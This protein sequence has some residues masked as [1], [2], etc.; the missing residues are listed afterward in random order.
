MYGPNTNIVVNG[1][2]IFFSECEIR[3]IL[4]CLALVLSGDRQVIEV[5]Q[6]VHDAYN[7][8]IDEGNRNMAWGAPNVRSWY[9]NSKGRVTQNWPFTL[10]EYWERTRSPDET[11]FRFG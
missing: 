10:R 7:E 3:Y 11:D 6:D 9:K 5:K 4:G 8:I 2:I 1:S